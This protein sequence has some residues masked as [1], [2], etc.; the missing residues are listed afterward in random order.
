MTEQSRYVGQ[1][2]M[3]VGP[4]T[5]EGQR[6]RLLPMTRENIDA[7]FTAAAFPEIWKHTGTNPIDT[8]DDMAR[9]VE[10]ALAE[11]QAGSAFPLVMIDPAR[12]EVIGATRFANI[13]ATDRRLE[14]G[15]SWMRPDRQRTGVNGEAKSLMLRHAFD[16]WG[17]LRVEIKTDVRNARSR[18]AIERIGGTCEGIFRQHMVVREGRVRDTAYYSIIDRDWRDPNHRAYLNA[19]S[20]GIT[21]RAEA[22]A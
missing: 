3:H 14:I 5:L 16:V 22:V 8:R 4:V 11:Q 12:N 21:P 10:R 17:A 6:V 1:A 2:P 13:S 19:V 20:Y 7:L 15:W 9:Y 18:A